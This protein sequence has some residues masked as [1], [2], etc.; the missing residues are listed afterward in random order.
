MSF[1]TLREARK[2][3]KA[4]NKASKKGVGSNKRV[5]KK[6]TAHLTEHQMSACRGAYRAKVKNYLQSMQSAAVTL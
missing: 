2:E 6:S 4:G 1:A 3:V 5:I